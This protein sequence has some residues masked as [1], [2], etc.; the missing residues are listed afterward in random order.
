MQF[1]RVPA[2]LILSWVPW[3]P[4]GDLGKALR[5]R[6]QADQQFPRSIKLGIRAVGWFELE[7]REWLATRLA[8][9]RDKQL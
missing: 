9:S 3:D 4:D 5:F 2:S 8:S 1:R 6:L 7:V